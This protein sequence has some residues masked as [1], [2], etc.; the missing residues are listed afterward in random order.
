VLVLS[1]AAL[2]AKE[3]PHAFRGAGHFTSQTDFVS[4][5]IATHLGQ[6][7]EVGSITD[8]QPSGEPGVFLITAWAIHTAADGAEL[9]ETI[10]GQ[11]NFLTGAGSATVTYV[12]GTGRFVDASGTAALELQLAPNGSFS[13]TGIGTL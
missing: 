12:G 6:F 10:S 1:T 3:R 13:Y 8:I 9:H 4:K 5:G 11:L 2:V 7:T